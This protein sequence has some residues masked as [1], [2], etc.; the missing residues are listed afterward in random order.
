[1][2]VTGPGVR[3]PNSPLLAFI[4]FAIKAFFIPD[5]FVVA[6][7]IPTMKFDSNTIVSKLDNGIILLANGILLLMISSFIAG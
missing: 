6:L 4:A 5:V 3:I 2:T 7:L 1:L